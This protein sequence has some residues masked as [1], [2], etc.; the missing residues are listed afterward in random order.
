MKYQ[1]AQSCM[2][3]IIDEMSIGD[4]MIGNAQPTEMNNNEIIMAA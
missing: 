1:E 3:A 2:Y 4:S